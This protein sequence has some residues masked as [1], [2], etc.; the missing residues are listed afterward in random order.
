[1]RQP[2]KG[3]VFLALSLML[4]AAAVWYSSRQ[5][6][7]RLPTGGGVA[8]VVLGDSHGVILASDGSLWVW[9]AAESGFPVLGLGRVQTQARLRR[10]GTNTD[11]V[12]VA[13][14]VSHTLALKADGTIWAWGENFAWQLGDG[15]TASRS[16]PVR[17]VSG[18]DWKQVATGQHG[19][20]LK[21]NGTLWAWGDNWAGV[22]GNGTTSNSPVPVPA[23]GSTNWVKVWANNVENIGLQ[24]DGS[25]WFWGHRYL[26]FGP[27]GQSSLVPTRLSPD[28]N[29]VDVGLG[30]FMGFAIKADGTLWAWGADADIY[31]GAPNPALNGVPRQVGTNHDWQA[32]SPFWNSCV[33]LMKQ[34]GSL[35]AL[36]DVLDQRGQRLH[37]AAWQ[38]QPVRLRRI[39]V[40]KDIV[41]FAGGRQRLGVALTRDGEVWTW[42][43][44]LG[45]RTPTTSVVFTLSRILNRL[46]VVNRWSLGRPDPVIHPEPWLLTHEPP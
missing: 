45:Q 13:A 36:D 34:D 26:Q 16:T 41:A 17:S 33:L 5:P 11:W 8:K 23:G 18:N 27:K 1:M 19:L 38:M 4:V 46:G 6:R 24:A 12:D 39:N 29:W 3:A 42:G 2:S 7:L 28:T 9:G 25:V 40:P 32:C 14:G 22:L 30:D 43:W 37:N 35:W 21:H 20:A 31:T 15:T 10:L 44:A